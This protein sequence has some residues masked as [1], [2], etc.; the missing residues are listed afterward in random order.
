MQ[1]DPDDLRDVVEHLI[2]LQGR[3]HPGRPT[4]YAL[5]RAARAVE[6]AGQELARARAAYGARPAE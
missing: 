3:Q 4:F 1:N 5:A 6:E 2:R